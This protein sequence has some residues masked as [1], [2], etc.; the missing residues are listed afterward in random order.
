[1]KRAK[2]LM[3]ALLTFTCISVPLTACGG[4]TSSATSQTS[5][6]IRVQSIEITKMPTKTVYEVGDLFE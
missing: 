1:M 3:V 6:Q 4:K 2:K 5:Q